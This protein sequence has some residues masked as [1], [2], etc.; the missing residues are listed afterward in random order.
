MSTPLI[1]C[2]SGAATDSAM[3]SAD[4]PGYWAFTAM[5][6][7]VSSGYW[8]IGKLSIETMPASKINKDITVAKMG[9][10]IKNLENIFTPL[11]FIFQNGVG[12]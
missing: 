7:G 8:A 5:E 2:S 3:T 10:S 12:N 11:L 9:R 6:G 4:A 1:F